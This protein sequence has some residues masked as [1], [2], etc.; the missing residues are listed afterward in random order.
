VLGDLI[1]PG[2]VRDGAVEVVV[3]WQA[4]R[5]G[6]VHPRSCQ[7]VLVDQVLYR[8]RPADP[9]IGGLAALLVLGAEVR[10]QVRVAHPVQ[11]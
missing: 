7:L 2:A 8:Q 10:Q 1:E 4:V 11:P 6:C 5:F 9:V 3:A